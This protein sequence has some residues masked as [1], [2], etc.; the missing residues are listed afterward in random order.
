MNN[1]FNANVANPPQAIPVTES[2]FEGTFWG[3]LGVNFVVY[4]VSIITLSLAW[5]AMC[6]FRLR[7]VY[8]NTIIGG[9]RLKFTGTGGQLFGKY[10]SWLL[11]SIVTIGVYALFVPIK[12]KKWETKHVE[13]ASKLVY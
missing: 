8:S 9:Y 4:F 3:N 12:Y 1:D 5:P 13:I 10:I 11:L 7:W 6:C 2:R